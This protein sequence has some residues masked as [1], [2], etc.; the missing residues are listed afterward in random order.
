[1]FSNNPNHEEIEDLRAIRLANTSNS[2][3]CATKKVIILGDTGVGKSCILNRLTHD[4]F[5]SEHN[6][7][8]G[9]E[10]GSLSV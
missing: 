2:E 8:I 9:V 4:R 5:D 3:A 6:C 7:T 1:M 10:F